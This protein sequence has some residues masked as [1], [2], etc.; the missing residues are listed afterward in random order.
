MNETRQLL[1]T[2]KRRFKARGLTYRQAGDALGLSEP[3]IKRL[4]STGNMSL[5]RLCELA[6]LADLTLAELA[7]ESL[8][9]PSLHHLNGEQEQELVADIHLLLVA[10]C[11]L[12][13]W[14]VEQIITVYALSET[15][16]VQ[17]LLRLDKLGLI[18]LMPGNRIRLLVARDF[19]WLPD[20]P[21]RGFFRDKGRPDFLDA[22]FA[23]ADETMLFLHGMLTPAAAMQF[24]Q[25]LRRLKQEFADLHRDSLA[26]PLSFRRGTG[27][28]I[29]MREWEP[30]AFSAL[31]RPAEA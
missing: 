7:A 30:A 20:G 27:M 13:H 24:R 3:S 26:V 16:C 4:F 18:A 15:V 2:L 29:A 14:A 23:A 22:N 31:R 5:Q 9:E 19:D 28:L 8:A 11:A 17:K 21:I 10:V 1:A 25:K 12:N 6:A